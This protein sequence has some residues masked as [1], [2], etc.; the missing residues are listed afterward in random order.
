MTSRPHHGVSSWSP[1]TGPPV[2]WHDGDAGRQFFDGRNWSDPAPIVL[3]AGVGIGALVVL[4]ASLLVA[5]LLVVVLEPVGVHVGVLVGLLIL[6]G[7]GPPAWWCIWSVKRAVGPHWRSS[8]GWSFRGIDLAWGLLA[9]LGALIAQA[10]VI[11][12]LISIDVPVTSNT[13]GLGDEGIPG[14]YVV[15]TSVAAVVAAPVVEE[16]VF[17]GVVLSSLSSRLGRVGAV[18]VQGLLFGA[19]HADP[20][21]GWSN[22][23]LAIVLG[24]V[25]VV[26]GI[27][28]ELT[29]RLSPAI[30]A[31]AVFNGVVLIALFSGLVPS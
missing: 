27:V 7:Y 14:W 5:R 1:P 31:H 17:R 12:V 8:I 23:G 19:V 25:G 3:P 10:V 16:L 30:V 15:A 29:G 28:V 21:F 20:M 11:A 18:A 9:W 26:F 6:I 13:G 24:T 4:A 2:G 22:V